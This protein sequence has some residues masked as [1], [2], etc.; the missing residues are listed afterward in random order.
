MRDMK[1]DFPFFTKHPETIYLDTASTALKPSAVIRA[2][3]RYY[4]EYPVNIHRGIYD[5]SGYATEQ[6]EGARKKVADF[7]HVNQEEIIFTGGTTHSL[8]VLAQALEDTVQEGDNIVLTRMEH[9]AN[10]LPWQQLA[11]KKQCDLRFIELTAT[12]E[13]DMESAK[14]LIDNRTKVVSVTMVSNVLGTIVPCKEIIA[15]A[16]EVG[17]KTVLDAAQG[18]VHDEVDVKDLD[19][20]FLIFSG[21]KLYGPTGVGVLYGKKSSLEQLP[22]FFVGG[23]M[24]RTVT[25][26]SAEWMDAPGKFEAGTPP[27]AEVIGLGAAIEYMQSRWDRIKQHEQEVLSYALEAIQK[28]VDI[29]GPGTVQKQSGVISFLIPGI[30]PHDVGE[31]LNEKGIAV[32][33]GHHCAMPLMNYLNIVGTVRASFGLYSTKEDVDVLVEGIRHAKHIFTV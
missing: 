5:V 10:L 8:N 21:H 28:E 26:D 25:Y 16:K 4:E 31:L 24:I 18:I 27:I 13:I 1:K 19:C 6:F 2:V 23:D 17:A 7:I 3:T 15:Y 20:D 32:R 9:H 33:V 30:H 11:K 12:F 29:I 22:P 14:K